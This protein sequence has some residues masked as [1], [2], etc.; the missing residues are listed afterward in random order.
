MA[1]L[2]INCIFFNLAF[3]AAIARMDGAE[4]QRT[5]DRLREAIVKCP[6]SLS[7]ESFWAHMQACSDDEWRRTMERIGGRCCLRV[8]FGT[9]PPQ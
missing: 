1:A 6:N 2:K 3:N 7:L 4:R 5:L 8:A 9:R